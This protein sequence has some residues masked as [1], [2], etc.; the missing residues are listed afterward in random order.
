MLQLMRL[1]LMRT[2]IKYVHTQIYMHVYTHVCTHVHTHVHTHV[3]VRV[4]MHVCSIS[5]HMP[6][7]CPH[8][9]LNTCQ[10]TCLHTLALLCHE[11]G[12]E[13]LHTLVLPPLPLHLACGHIRYCSRISGRRAGGE[14]GTREVCEST[15]VDRRPARS[16][17]RDSDTQGTDIVE[18]R[19]PKGKEGLRGVRGTMSSCCCC[20]A[21]IVLSRSPFTYANTP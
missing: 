16:N 4:H 10:Q 5:T 11:L 6:A 14:K 15:D 21:V 12:L 19:A 8:T 18:S 20:I 17:S 2:T 13:L 1:H 9:C 3:Y 7:A